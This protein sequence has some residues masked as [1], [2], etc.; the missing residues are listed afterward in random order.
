VELSPSLCFIPK[1]I[2][3]LLK[4]IGEAFKVVYCIFAGELG[5]HD[6]MHMVSQGGRHLI[7]KLRYHSA[8]SFPYDGPYWGRG[9]RRKYGHKLDDRTMASEYLKATCIDEDIETSIYQLSR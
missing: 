4:Q 7:A 3:R 8:L 2:Q 5:Q 6:A 9:P 1:H